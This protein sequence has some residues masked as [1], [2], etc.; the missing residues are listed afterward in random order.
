MDEQQSTIEQDIAQGAKKRRKGIMFFWAFLAVVLVIGGLLFFKT[1]KTFKSISLNLKDWQKAQAVLPDPEN[2]PDKEANRLNILL[3]GLRGAD[4]PNGGLLTD[5]MMIMSIKQDT[6][7]V[8]FIS[9]PRDLYLDM[10][11]YPRKQKIN[12]AYA[13]GEQ[14]SSNGGGL[15]YARQVIS[16]VTGLYIDYVAAVNF[17]AFRDII[18]EL[19]GIDISRQTPFSE[20]T[21]WIYEGKSDSP[22]WRKTS[23]ST[24]EFYV[25]AGQNHFDGE[26]ALYYS[27]SRYSTSD[28]DR[29]RRQQEV[30]R[31]TKD[32]ALSLGVLANPIKIYNLLTAVERN[33]RTNLTFDQIKNLLPLAQSLNFSNTKSLVFDTSPNSLFYSSTSDEGS[34]IIL[35]KGDNFDQTQAKCRNIFN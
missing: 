32:K 21:Q 27:R 34:Y 35:P 22:Y 3:L 25:S 30:I 31:A 4:D 14:R 11:N 12:F 10:P 5:T 9:V 6:N 2:S 19:G 26:S 15:V 1:G 7:Q 16:Q 23:S 8:A 29:M 33:V 24:W 18:N 20:R 13:L 28:F 17:D